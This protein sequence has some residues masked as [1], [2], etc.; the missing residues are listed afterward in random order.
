[1]LA[2]A[3]LPG[4]LDVIPPRIGC[5]PDA[6]IVGLRVPTVSALEVNV[7]VNP[8][9]QGGGAGT[10][11]VENVLTEVVR[12]GN[13]QPGIFRHNCQ[14]RL[15]YLV[16]WICA[17]PDPST[18]GTLDPMGQTLPRVVLGVS[19]RKTALGKEL[20]TPYKQLLK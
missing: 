1:M 8:L 2:T 6:F 16:P 15:I 12:F 4:D 19:I 5:I 17:N 14:E 13:Y 9:P 11:K 20:P 10:E 3:Q 7:P 18:Q